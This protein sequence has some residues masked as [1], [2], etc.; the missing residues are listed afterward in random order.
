M[1]EDQLLNELKKM[2]A[3]GV[4]L[5]SFPSII[6]CKVTE[7]EVP[8]SFCF[9]NGRLSELTEGVFYE[10]H[11][12]LVKNIPEKQAVFQPCSHWGCVW[13]AFGQ[14]LPPMSMIHAKKFFGEVPCT[15]ELFLEQIN[16][17]LAQAL[18]DQVKAFY[19]KSFPYKM[20]AVLLDQIGPLLLGDT[21]A[22]VIAKAKHLEEAAAIAYQVR[23]VEDVTYRHMHYA[24]MEKFYTEDPVKL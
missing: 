13:A 24:L 6:T 1:T 20:N 8:Q 4:I 16:G 10:L 7:S 12:L 14:A 9:Q 23:S 11:R 21:A 19:D 5:S 2:E 15:G 22:D 3:D 17:N 18:Y